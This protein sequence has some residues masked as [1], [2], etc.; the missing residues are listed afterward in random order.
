MNNYIGNIKD[1][2][3][4]IKA[5]NWQ[6]ALWNSIGI[7]WAVLALVFTVMIILC[8][9]TITFI[10]AK[11]LSFSSG[12]DRE[13]EDRISRIRSM[14]YAPGFNYI[15]SNYIRISDAAVNHV[16]K[17]QVSSYLSRKRYAA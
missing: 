5:T 4:T 1:A 13:I 15:S 3:E 12:I 8:S 14:R 7:S 16:S 6:K 17:N 2:I 10:V 11:L 9:L